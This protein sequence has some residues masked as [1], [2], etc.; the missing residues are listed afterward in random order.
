MLTCTMPIHLTRNFKAFIFKSPLKGLIPQKRDIE[1]D[2]AD[3]FIE[4]YLDLSDG[5]FL[6]DTSPLQSGCNCHACRSHTRSYIHHLFKSEEL[7][8]E[9]LLYIH[10]QYQ[11]T[12]F[13]EDIRL[14]LNDRDGFVKWAN[15]DPKYYS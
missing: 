15:L 1:G 9:V 3:K 12:Q 7:L 8:G 11:V 14:R 4:E 5:K 6:K 13:M 2:T 10:N